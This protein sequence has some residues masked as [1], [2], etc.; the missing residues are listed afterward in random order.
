MLSGKFLYQ[1]GSEVPV[2]SGT[3]VPEGMAVL[4]TMSKESSAGSMVEG[5]MARSMSI[6]RA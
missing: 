1:S 6:A 4:S 2:G 5:S 3:L